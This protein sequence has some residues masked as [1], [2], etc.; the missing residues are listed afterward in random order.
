MV[1]RHALLYSG[2]DADSIRRKYTIMYRKK[3]TIGDP[4][5]TEDVQLTDRAKHVIGVKASLSGEGRN[6]V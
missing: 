6:T 2:R 4:N 5:I 1:E 3:I